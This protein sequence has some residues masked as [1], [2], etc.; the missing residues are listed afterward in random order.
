MAAGGA[1]PAVCKTLS[2]TR[3]HKHRSSP[4]SHPLLSR[5]VQPS[6]SMGC[7]SCRLPG[8]RR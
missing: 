2:L 1:M 5:P 8:R 4:P 7:T 6:P 3:I